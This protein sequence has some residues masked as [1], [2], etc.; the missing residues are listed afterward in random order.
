[1]KLSR[2]C[3]YALLA[4]EYLAAQGDGQPVASPLIARARGIS[5][6]FLVKAL[7]PLVRAGLLLSLKGPSGGYRLARPATKISLLEVVEAIDGPVRG[8]MPG[9]LEGGDRLESRVHAVCEGVAD[10]MRRR[11]GQVRLSDLAGKK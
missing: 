9:A 3:G 5:E 1:M 6:R 4:L 8:D 7:T 2:T 11:L 10:L